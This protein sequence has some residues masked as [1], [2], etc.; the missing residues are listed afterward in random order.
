MKVLVGGDGAVEFR[1]CLSELSGDLL[2]AGVS[3]GD[4]RNVSEVRWMC[5]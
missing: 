3:S 2:N 1:L 4:A 5:S